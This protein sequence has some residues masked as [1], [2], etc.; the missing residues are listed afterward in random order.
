MTKIALITDTHWG[1]RNDHQ[2]FL[3]STKKFLDDVFFPYLKENRV[4]TVVHLGDLTDRRKYINYFTAQ[5]LR[6]DFI[7]PLLD[8][9]NMHFLWILGNHDLYYRQ[10]TEVSSAS[11]LFGKGYKKNFTFFKNAREVTFDGCKILFVPW[12]CDENREETKKIIEASKAQV[13]LGHLELNGFEMFR[14]VVNHVG[15]D[16][17]VYKRF[18][19]VCTGHYHH[20]STLGNINYLG[21]H[22][23]FTWA[24]YND[25]RGFHILDTSTLKLTFIDNP[26]KNFVKLYYDDSSEVSES[27][28]FGSLTE[29]FLK[30]VVK[31]RT[32]SIKYDQFIS[33]CEEA[34]PLDIQ[35]VEDHLNLDLPSDD[36]IVSGTKDTLTIIRE[37][38]A[39]SNNTV[40]STKLDSLFINL[41]QE[42][43]S[44][45]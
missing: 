27:T 25:S 43:T 40:N 5:R 14:G 21:A 29:K 39:Q 44:A 41:Y 12:I 1:I 22:A 19:L 7:D 35:I 37:Y 26:F 4:E 45:E 23:D 10:T 28:D 9:P 31:S 30:I 17:E 32:N 33:R 3:N 13:L 8:M 34:N 2:A 15:E 18:P 38:I 24:D 16:P 36:N 42:A 6:K 20:R 11:E